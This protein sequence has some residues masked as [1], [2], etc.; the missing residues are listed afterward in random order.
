[1]RRFRPF[2]ARFSAM[3]APIPEQRGLVIVRLEDGERR[4]E[5]LDV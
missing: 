1:M 2:E 3:D 5:G 4:G